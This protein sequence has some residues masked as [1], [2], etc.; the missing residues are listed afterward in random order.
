MNAESKVE[1]RGRRETEDSFIPL[2]EIAG[3]I[4]GQVSLRQ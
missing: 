1:Y 4:A 3:H 2:A